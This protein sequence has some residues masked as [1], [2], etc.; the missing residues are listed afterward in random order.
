ME[1]FEVT[2]AAVDLGVAFSVGQENITVDIIE[3]VMDG[4]CYYAT[5]QY[6]YLDYGM[7]SFFGFKEVFVLPACV[8]AWSMA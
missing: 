1:T 4:K 3:D 6:I 8:G 2:L 5:D 7:H